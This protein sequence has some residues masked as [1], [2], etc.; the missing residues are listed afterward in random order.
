MWYWGTKIQNQHF[1]FNRALPIKVLTTSLEEEVL[2]GD[3]KGRALMTL[4]FLAQLAGGF[5]N[6]PPEGA[7]KGGF[8][9][10]SGINRLPWG[11]RIICP[12]R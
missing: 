3:K 6:P 4:L 5:P 11:K 8:I 10:T 1:S 9:E 2:F 12:I 7:L